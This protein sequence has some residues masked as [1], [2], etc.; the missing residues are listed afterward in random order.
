M[1]RKEINLE[2]VFLDIETF[3]RVDLKN[4]SVYRYVEDPDFQ[5]LMLSY[6]VGWDAPVQSTTNPDRIREIARLAEDPNYTIW[7][8]NANFERIC[9]S[10]VLGYAVGYGEYLSPENFEDT[11]ALAAEWGYPQRLDRLALALGGEQKDEAGTRLINLFSKPNRAGERILPEDRPEEWQ[12]FLDYCDQDVVTLRDVAS[13][14]RGWPT[15]SEREVWIADQYINDYGIDVDVELAEIAVD[16]SGTNRIEQELEISSL[17][18]IL[19]PNSTQQLL[20]WFTSSGLEIPDMKA[21]TVR[22]F[23]AREDLTSTQRRVLELRQDLAL[24]ASSKYIAALNRVNSDRRLRGSFQFFGAHTGRWAG[25]GVQLQNLPSASLPILDDEGQELDDPTNDQINRSIESNILDLKMGNGAD[26]NTLKSLIRPM[27]RGP[28]AV[29]DYAA[30]E[31]RVLAWLAGE[32][33]ALEAF[34]AGRD[35]YVE[36]A[37][38]MGGLTRDEGKVA[39]LALGYNGGI[40]SLRSMNAKGSDEKLQMYVNQWRGTNQEIV[41][42]WPS[43]EMAFRNGNTQLGEHVYI[44]RGGDSE[45]RIVLPSGRGISYH[46]VGTKWGTTPWGSPVRQ[47]SFTDARNYPRRL[48]T[49]GGRLTE[50]ITQAVA[51]DVLAAAVLRVRGAGYRVVGHVHD[52]ILVEA[53][54]DDELDEITQLIITPEPWMDGLPI[55]AEGFIAPRYRKD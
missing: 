27:F 39:V 18:G 42:F 46:R 50:N 37:E 25:R 38:R 41:D 28:I 47:L 11:Q 4:S 40:G 10:A 35:I 9:F 20:S 22:G 5:I 33:W 29:V 44:E 26:A 48:D 55:A 7:A 6:A 53:S 3:S 32:T 54:T 24:T 51:R 13:R 30:I 16:E 31:A 36:T 19:N 8:H 23:L 45:R 14:L 12:E 17:T 21:A 1:Y 15:D 2:D 49:Y 52:E 43:T 34:Q